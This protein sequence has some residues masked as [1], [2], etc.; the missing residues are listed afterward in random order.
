MRH[1][2]YNHNMLYWECKRRLNSLREFHSLAVTYYS[3]LHLRELGS[4]SEKQEALQARVE[5]N[6]RIGEVSYSCR[7]I[8]ETFTMYYSP[9]AVTGG[10]AGPVNLLTNMF[11]LWRLQISSREFLDILE[12][13]IGHYEREVPLLYKRIFNPLFWATWLLSKIL[14]LPF[15]ILHLAGFET[16]R[17]EKSPIGKLVKAIFG[18]AVFASALLTTL[19]LL[20]L[21]EH[22]KRAVRTVL[23]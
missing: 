23:P 15:V 7:L 21:L 2:R 11:T 10:L 3:N 12:R 6:R 20:D 16:Q 19:E 4:P 1:S 17:I 18:F 8:G 5:L 9:P 22:F 13:A 14:S